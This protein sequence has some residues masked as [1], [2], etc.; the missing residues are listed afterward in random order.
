MGFS[1]IIKMIDNLT[2]LKKQQTDDDSTKY[3]VAELDKAEQE[4]AELQEDTGHQGDE[5]LQALDASLEKDCAWV[6]RHFDSP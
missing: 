4:F 5:G 2:V 6:K 3:C 1:K